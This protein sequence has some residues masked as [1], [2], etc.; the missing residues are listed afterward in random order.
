MHPTDVVRTDY[1]FLQI[2]L[3]NKLARP[4]GAAL[5]SLGPTLGAVVDAIGGLLVKG[6]G[7]VEACPTFNYTGLNNYTTYCGVRQQPGRVQ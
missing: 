6:P 5:I 3:E 7:G 4:A 2:D 1:R